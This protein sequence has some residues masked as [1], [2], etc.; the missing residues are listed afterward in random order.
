VI[1]GTA[2]NLHE[3]IS[4]FEE[5]RSSDRINVIGKRKKNTKDSE[6]RRLSV[7]FLCTGGTCV[8]FV[9]VIFGIFFLFFFPFVPY[10]AKVVYC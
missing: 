7:V 1:I 3:S 10:W 5:L 2:E 9:W 4:E 8:P 6:R